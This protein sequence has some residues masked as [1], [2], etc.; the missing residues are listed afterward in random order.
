M[1][2][3]RRLRSSVVEC[4]M[5]LVVTPSVDGDV[6]NAGMTRADA[7]DANITAITM[8]IRI[9]VVVDDVKSLF[10]KVCL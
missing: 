1:S 8:A 4:L 5:L 9:L 3:S 10:R 7:T 6:K 2:T